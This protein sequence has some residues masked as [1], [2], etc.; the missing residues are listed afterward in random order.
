M[1]AVRY[2]SPG[3][4]AVQDLP[5][6][7]IKH[8]EVLVAM[9][10]C[11]ICGTDVKTFVRGHPLI[12]P[13][14]VLGHEVAGVVTATEHPNFNIGD[15]V[16]VAPYAPCLQCTNCQRG[17][18][19]LCENLFESSLDPGG[20]AEVIRVPRRIADQVLFKIPDDLDFDTAALTE[21]LACC[22]HGLEALHFQHNQSLLVIGDGPMGLLQA[23]VGKALGASPVILCG[24]TPNRLAFAAQVA[25]H[26]ID[27]SKQD[28]A[29][30]LHDLL[31][32][33]PENVLVSVGSVDLVRQALELVG[34]G[35]AVNIFAGMPKDATFAMPI[36]RV[37]Y[38][39]VKVVGTFGF[40]PQHFRRALDLLT[41]GTLSLAGFVTQKVHLDGVEAALQAAS[42][43]EEIKVVAI[44]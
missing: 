25:D 4:V 40:G 8:G 21:P 34:K 24:M 44:T 16:V 41:S 12:P 37:H 2:Y 42:R 31:P 29:A 38:D 10:A 3:K 30:T 33:G 17:H 9:K 35:G 39:E 15:R 13:G 19:S 27:S 22:I 11:G 5:P 43:Y 6:P 14:S 36:Y 7:Q 28:L 20:F 26:I 18:F 1:K 32:A 23:A